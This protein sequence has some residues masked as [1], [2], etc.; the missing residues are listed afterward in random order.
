MCKHT[1]NGNRAGARSVI[2]K[3]EVIMSN[4]GYC[5]FQNTL[6][7]LQDCYDS[8]GDGDFSEEEERARKR[9][10]ELCQDIANEYGE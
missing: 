2:T 7:D 8:M 3:Q 9:L 6:P 1:G 4:M 10:I 5:R